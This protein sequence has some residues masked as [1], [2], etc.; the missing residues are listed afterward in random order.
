MFHKLFVSIFLLLAF[1]THSALS[2]ITGISYSSG[3]ITG[4]TFTVDLHTDSSKSI[5]FCVA[6]GLN[7]GWTYPLDHALGEVVFTKPG[8]CY[9]FDGHGSRTLKVTLSFP[10]NFK[11]PSPYTGLYML[12]AAVFRVVSWVAAAMNPLIWLGFAH[13]ILFVC[14][15]WWAIESNGCGSLPYY[16]RHQVIS[17]MAFKSYMRVLSWD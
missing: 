16:S 17:E 5:E 2:N 9:Q 15:E 1:A 12:M 14:V 6:F 10:K 7:P 11:C 13:S 3:L 8:T 4:S